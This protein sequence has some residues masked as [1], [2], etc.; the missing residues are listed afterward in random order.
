MV[1]INQNYLLVYPKYLSEKLFYCKCRHIFFLKSFW[2]GEHW[3]QQGYTQNMQKQKPPWFSSKLLAVKFLVI[4][5][6]LCCQQ[7]NNIHQACVLHAIKRGQ[8]HEGTKHLLL[9]SG[10]SFTGTTPLTSERF[11]LYWC[12]PGGNLAFQLYVS[13]LNNRHW[14]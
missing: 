12:T 5:I 6:N 8:T 14:G 7:G 2:K 10:I 13:F 9:D 3:I 11:H 4:R 1:L